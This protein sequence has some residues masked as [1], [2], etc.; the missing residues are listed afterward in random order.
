MN[1]T[2]LYTKQMK[3]NVVIIIHGRS[4]QNKNNSKITFFFYY[5]VGVKNENRQ[6]PSTLNFYFKRIITD[7][8]IFSH[9]KFST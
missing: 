7:V 4:K 5:A 8:R 9:Q 1:E 3:Y 6:K 2:Q